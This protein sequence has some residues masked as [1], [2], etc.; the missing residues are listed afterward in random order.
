ML[1]KSLYKIVAAKDELQKPADLEKKRI[2]ITALGGAN[3]FVVSM[4]LKEWK[5]PETSVKMLATGRGSSRIASVLAGGTDATVLP[6]DSARIAVDKGLHVVADLADI[7]KEFP[8][9]MIIVQ[10]SFLDQE[11]DK[12]KQFMQALSEAIFVLQKGIQT[13]SS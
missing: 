11:R 13:G 5:I 4:A 9:K 7:V 1:N 12:V 3:E 6:Y 10:R 2:G 8:D